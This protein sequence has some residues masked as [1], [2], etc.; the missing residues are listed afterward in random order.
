M[1]DTPPDNPSTPSATPD[2][3]AGASSPTPGPDTVQG[4][5]PLPALP[6]PG[7]ALT[8]AQA[9]AVQRACDAAT[10]IARAELDQLKAE[11]A[12]LKVAKLRRE[13]EAAR[14]GTIPPTPKQALLIASH[15][16]RQ[17]PAPDDP[18]PEDWNASV[19]AGLTAKEAKIVELYLLCTPKQVIASTVGM[20]ISGVEA[21]MKRDRV[22]AAMALGLHELG[23]TRMERMRRAFDM[24]VEHF[25]EVLE[26]DPDAIDDPGVKAAVLD[27]KTKSAAVLMTRVKPFALSE[28]QGDYT[29]AGAHS[30]EEWRRRYFESEKIVRPHKAQIAVLKCTA[31]Y[32]IAVAGI[33]SGKTWVSALVFWDRVMGWV[34]L[35]E[36]GPRG[37]FWM[38]APNSIVGAVMC[39]RFVELAPPGWI[40]D[41]T[42]GPNDRTWTL[43]D[44][45]RVQFRSGEHAED[46]VARTVHGAWV[47]EFT[48]CKAGLWRVSLRGRIATT[49]GFV[50]F[51][52]SP[53][54][55]N[56]TWDDIWKRTIVGSDAH[57]ID[58]AGY[59][60]PS[61]ENP[62]IPA[63][64]VESARRTLPAAFFKR[65]WCA[66]WDAFHGQIYEDWNP[67]TMVF[68]HA[69]DDPRRL[70]R[71]T[72]TVLAIDWGFAAAGCALAVRIY[73]NELVEVVDE[74][75]EAG[76]L[77]GWWDE[78]IARLWRLWR[79]HRI[80]AD[81][82][83]AARIATLA[84]D[85]LPIEGAA[86]D[87]G[88]GIRE[89]AK[90]IRQNRLRVHAKCANLIR[91]L[92]SYR[93]RELKGSETGERAE[94]P[95]KGDDHAVDPLRYALFS[96]A[97]RGASPEE[98]QTWRGKPRPLAPA[99]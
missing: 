8:P 45:S 55:K 90:A 44:G 1:S 89:V 62:A 49:R 98:R 53:R 85:G 38:I 43:K 9:E 7:Q 92:S 87:V 68:D 88:P 13:E 97:T 76:R 65:E 14:N 84:D 81:P 71:G 96:E 16:H 52:G 12:R 82:E 23:R 57:D 73:P 18:N 39:E 34:I 91:Q 50:V 10:A 78:Q 30:E 72:T 46:L 31:R 48:L 19:W 83:G 56:W 5:A 70:P 69:P 42:G 20:S 25:S 15:E 6:A 59:T 60:W 66:S 58:Y 77:D 35:H 79:A 40:V 86:N 32:V 37:F 3:A 4:S 99:R 64:E 75:Y 36:T 61:S 27:A 22:K 11:E 2:D 28:L 95:Q 93:W 33:Q 17:G 47:D 24:A 63:E 94:V 74:V 29:E 26:S 80:W 67:E 54:G 41:T 51:S 21:A